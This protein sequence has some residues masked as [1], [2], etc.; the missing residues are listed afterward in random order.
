MRTG[1]VR[2]FFLFKAASLVVLIL[3][4]IAVEVGAL[5]GTGPLLGHP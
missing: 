4:G 5:G 3:L 2:E 1:I